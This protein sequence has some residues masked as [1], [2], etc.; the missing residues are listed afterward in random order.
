MVLI[1]LKIFAGIIVFGLIMA[2]CALVIGLFA[3]IIGG[4]EQIHLWKLVDFSLWVPIM[5]IFIVLIPVILLIYLLMCLIA[6]RQP[7]RQ[8]VLNIFTP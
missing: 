1:L 6:S 5:G 3:V 2:A 7:G 8:D 4:P